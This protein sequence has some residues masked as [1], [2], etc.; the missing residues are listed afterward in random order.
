MD[1]IGFP[2][3]NRNVKPALDRIHSLFDALQTYENYLQWYIKN[4][5]SGA[6][7][8]IALIRSMVFK[9]RALLLDETTSALDVDN[10]Q[11]V[12]KVVASLNAEGVTVLWI[13]HTPEQ[14]RKHANKILTIESGKI[15]SF[16]VLKNDPISVD[17]SVVSSSLVLITLFFSYR[18]KLKQEK[19]VGGGVIRAIVQLVIVGYILEFVF[20]YKN[21][22]FT[23][24]L[25]LFMIV[26]AAHNAT[27]RGAKVRNKLVI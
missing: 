26:N 11:I 25:L 6:K 8:R 20:G 22:I 27:K 17:S 13:S 12:E 24:L 4:R 19:D 16:E 1:N 2:F 23:T 14:S 3:S 10:T 15:K 7:Q 9:P 5:S 18:Q 21:P